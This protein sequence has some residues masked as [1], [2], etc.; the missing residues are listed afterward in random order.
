MLFVNDGR[1]QRKKGK[2]IRFT[3][4]RMFWIYGKPNAFWLMLLF[5]LTIKHTI[6]SIYQYVFYL[7]FFIFNFS[8]HSALCILCL[9]LSLTLC[10]GILLVCVI[11]I[12]RLFEH[13]TRS[14]ILFVENGNGSVCF[15]V[16]SPVEFQYKQSLSEICVC[17]F[18]FNKA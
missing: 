1:R 17:V 4:R 5:T 10:L 3:T 2:K 14:L 8:V 7:L 12:R 9:S 18:F 13:L 16:I 6:K 15:I 11:I